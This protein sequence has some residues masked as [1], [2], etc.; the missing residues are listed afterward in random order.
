M[1]LLAINAGGTGALIYAACRNGSPASEPDFYQRGLET[2]RRA[3]ERAASEQLGWNAAASI[4][5][6]VLRVVLTR[7]NGEAIAVDSA[8]AEVIHRSESGKWERVTLTRDEAGGVRGV[9]ARWE[10]GSYEVRVNVFS[11]GGSV[12]FVRT[13]VVKS[14]ART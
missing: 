13:M 10:P 9:L 2:D 5:N 7:A 14:G 11:G 3:G 12:R 8:W 6:G 4:E 1:V